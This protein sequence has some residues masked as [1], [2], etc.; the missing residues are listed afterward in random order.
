[1]STVLEINTCNFPNNTLHPGYRRK[2]KCIDSGQL[3]SK[4]II[5]G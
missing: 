4:N 3:F 5:K 1:M 2:N